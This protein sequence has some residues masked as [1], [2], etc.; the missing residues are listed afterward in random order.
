MIFDRT[1]TDVNTAK[2]LIETKVKKFITLTDAETATLERGT[3][4]INTLNRIE[5]KLAEL[6]TLL[7]SMGY[8]TEEFTSTTWTYSDYFHQADFDKMLN[9]LNKLKNA[10]FVS[11]TDVPNDNYRQYQTINAVEKILY[12][13]ER[14][15]GVMKNNYR[16]CGTF[17]C[18]V[19]GE[20][21]L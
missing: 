20:Y 13:I 3:L 17:E 1:Q 2:T 12:D 4:T 6:Q 9:S 21:S 5:N 7:N 18:G 19:K 15:I 14:L 8:F 10:F 11:V 16:K